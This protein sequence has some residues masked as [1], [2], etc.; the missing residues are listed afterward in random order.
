MH[1]LVINTYAAGLGSRHSSYNSHASRLSYTSHDI[2]AGGRHLAHGPFGQPVTKESQLIQR[3]RNMYGDHAMDKEDRNLDEVQ[4]SGS[5]DEIRKA[6][7][8]ERESAVAGQSSSQ[9]QSDAAAGEDLHGLLM[10]IWL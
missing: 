9:L 6:K 1:A 3:A 2:L 7:P 4:C 10:F 8:P 5:V